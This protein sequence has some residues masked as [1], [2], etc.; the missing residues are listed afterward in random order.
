VHFEEGGRRVVMTLDRACKKEQRHHP[1]LPAVRTVRMAPIRADGSVDW[2]AAREG[3]TRDFS[4]GGVAVLHK[5][6][7]QVDR[8]II[9][10][11]LDGRSVYLPAEIR[12]WKSLESGLMEIGCRFL[13][14]AASEAATSV[15]EQAQMGVAVGEVLQRLK[16]EEV[17]TDERRA[18]PRVGYSE[19]IGVEGPTATDPHFAYARDLSK[20]G[21]AFITTAAMTLESKVLTL[22]RKGSPPLRIRARVV[23]CV[24]VAEGFYDVGASFEA[25]ES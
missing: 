16:T 18:Y 24:A 14:A 23:R 8:I 3:M 1:R 19:R 17:P 12:H 11:D 15:G 7:A 13:V 4:K 21:M 2:E 22:P 25:L 20:G 10:M 9:A 5:D 6:L